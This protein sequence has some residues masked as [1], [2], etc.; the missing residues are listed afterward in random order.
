M[1]R[2]SFALTTDA[3]EALEK[4]VTRRLRWAFA[5]PGDRNLGV[6][7]LRT[8]NARLLH[9]HE[10]VS[11]RW[12]PLTDITEDDVAREGFPGKSPE[13]FIEFFE[14]SM[15]KSPHLVN[16]IEFRRPCFYCGKSVVKADDRLRL[17][18]LYLAHAACNEDA[19][20]SGAYA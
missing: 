7:R 20:A 6:D 9:V 18:N 8:K 13:W 16:R 5:R 15:G 3:Y 14:R 4:D 11:T 10:I 1:R 12:E 19:L 2:M 17:T